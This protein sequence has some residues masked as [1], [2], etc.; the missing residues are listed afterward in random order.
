MAAAVFPPYSRV[1]IVGLQARPELNSTV[2]VVW[3]V[4][5]GAEAE[6]LA[7]SGRSTLLRSHRLLACPRF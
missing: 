2:A 1:R 5:D 4:A 7:A 6:A 3:P